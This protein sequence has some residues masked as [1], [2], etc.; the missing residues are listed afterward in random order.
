[1]SKP[2]PKD[3]VTLEQLLQLKRHERP[4]TEFWNRF[5]SELQVKR[6]QALVENPSWLDRLRAA[7]RF[8]LLWV[9]PVGG[10]AALAFGLWMH[11]G[12]LQIPGYAGNQA[13]QVQ[14]R[15]AAGVAS[16]QERLMELAASAATADVSSSFSS[17]SLPQSAERVNVPPQFII[18]AL[19]SEDSQPTHFRRVMYTTDF[20][21]ERN[22][23]SRYVADPIS[24]PKGGAVVQPAVFTSGRNF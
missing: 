14:E 20:S 18:D 17:E 3:K 13:K 21:V 7:V 8:S 4:S 24:A 2:L 11:N 10:A 12:T 15:A 1:M 23:G 19:S 22:Q 16:A 6:L 9:A 5:E